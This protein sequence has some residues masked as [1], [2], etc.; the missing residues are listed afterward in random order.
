VSKKVSTLNK[1]QGFNVIAEMARIFPHTT[2][3]G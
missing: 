3:F 2:L 1:Q